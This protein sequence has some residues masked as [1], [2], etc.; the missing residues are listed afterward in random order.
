MGSERNIKISADIVEQKQ[1]HTIVSRILSIL[2]TLTQHLA[3][4]TLLL[5]AT[6]CENPKTALLQL[7]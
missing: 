4:S 2:D 3:I 1:P 7:V 6:H 5:R